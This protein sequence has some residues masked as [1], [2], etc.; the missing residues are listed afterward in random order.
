MYSVC[1][2][3][4]KVSVTMNYKR[5]TDKAMEWPDLLN[6]IYLCGTGIFLEHV[7]MCTNK[8]SKAAS[9]AQYE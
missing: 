9:S 1:K 6:I 7:N 4:S 8:F 2:L 5:Q 3:G